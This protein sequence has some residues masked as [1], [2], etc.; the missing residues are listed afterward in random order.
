MMSVGRS[1]L[2]RLCFYLYWLYFLSRLFPH[3]DKMTVSSSRFM[4]YF[5][6]N[7]SG[8][9]CFF[10]SSSNQNIRIEFYGLWLVCPESHA[11]PSSWANELRVMKIRLLLLEREDMNVD[12]HCVTFGHIQYL[13]R[14]SV[15]CLISQ[16]RI[17][18]LAASLS[19]QCTDFSLSYIFGFAHQF[20]YETMVYNQGFSGL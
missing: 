17:S 19:P 5:A 3:G 1:S 8:R 7:S 9:I 11:L 20:V 4:S 13:R 12:V 6:N 15:L 16:Q 10:P 18:H 14:F 2:F